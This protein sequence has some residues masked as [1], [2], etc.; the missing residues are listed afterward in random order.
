MVIIKIDSLDVIARRIKMARKS[1]GISQ[2]SL[3]KDVGVSQSTIA[4]IERDIEKLNPSYSMILKIVTT[5][6]DLGDNANTISSVSANDLMH[7]KIIYVRPEDKMSKAIKIMSSNDFSQL[8]VINQR[9]NVVGTIYQKNLLE[10]ISNPRKARSTSI[11]EVMEVALPQVDKNVK[12]SMIKTML[13]AWGAVLVSEKS[14]IIGIITV[15]D[16]FRKI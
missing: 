14:R 15:Y 12:I 6:N 2:A 13:E 11:S 10:Y 16:L 8:P 1:L 3:A 7:K 5:L 4:R 9:M